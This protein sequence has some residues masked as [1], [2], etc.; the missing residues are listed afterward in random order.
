M[1]RVKPSIFKG[2]CFNNCLI[3]VEICQCWDGI[4][5]LPVFYRILRHSW[6][7]ILFVWYTHTLILFFLLLVYN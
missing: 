4:V 2:T 5:Y 6:G 7:D 3:P 1:C